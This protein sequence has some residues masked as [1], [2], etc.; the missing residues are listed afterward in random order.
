MLAVTAVAEMAMTLPVSDVWLRLVA[1]SA[2]LLP[3]MIYAIVRPPTPKTKRISRKAAAT[4]EEVATNDWPAGYSDP[5][6]WTFLPS[7]GR[8]QANVPR[9]S[10]VDTDLCKLK[11]LAIHKPTHEKWRE[12]DYPYAWHLHGKKRTWE[13][14][15]Q[16]QFKKLPSHPL[17]VALEMGTPAEVSGM[18]RGLHEL[19]VAGVRSIVGDMYASPGSADGE[20]SEP[21]TMAT[22]F[23]VFDQFAV[24]AAG[25][26][27]ALHADLTGEGMLRTNGMKAYFAELRREMQELSTEKV[28]TFCFWGVARFLDVIRWRVQPPVGWEM[29]FN[30]FAKAPPIYFGIYE[31][32]DAKDGED[33]TRHLP[34][35]KTYYT[36]VAVWS[37][38]HPPADEVLN[39]LA[40]PGT[41]IGAMEDEK[42]AHAAIQRSQKQKRFINTLAVVARL[43]SCH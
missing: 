10:V 36:R 6:R 29:D 43:C 31:L 39:R 13:V 26:E 27:P 1:C 15:L 25:E 18:T 37:A 3:W 32:E 35:R 8:L 28:Y 24:H 11:V 30:V 16:M 33:S 23:R 12:D 2:L 40:P 4:E 38:A 9:A 20:E 14:R 7:T 42:T 22:D 34:S 41:N 21:A 19:L 5:F 17:W